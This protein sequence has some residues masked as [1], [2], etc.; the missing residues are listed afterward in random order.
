MLFDVKKS[1]T[2]FEADCTVCASSSKS[3][4]PA[5]VDVNGLCDLKL[6]GND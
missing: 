5:I 6:P 4:L 3:M 1:L 2:T